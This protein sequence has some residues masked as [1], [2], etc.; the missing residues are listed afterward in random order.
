[1]DSKSLNCCR[2][3]DIEFDEIHGLKIAF[4][5][6]EIFRNL[7]IFRNCSTQ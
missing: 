3:A 7:D 2:R 4:L 1:M 5:D 6:P